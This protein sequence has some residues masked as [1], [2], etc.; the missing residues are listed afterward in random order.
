MEVT[1]K[2]N[3]GDILLHSIYFDEITYRNLKPLD[4]SE[5]DLISNGEAKLSIDRACVSLTANNYALQLTLT[6]YAEERFNFKVVCTGIFDIPVG[7][8]Q[9]S[10]HI[11]TVKDY[12][13]SCTAIMFPFLREKVMT[14]VNGAGLYNITIAPIDTISIFE[15][16][17]LE[18][19]ELSKNDYR[20]PENEVDKFLDLICDKFINPKENT[21]LRDDIVQIFHDVKPYIRKRNI[22]E[23]IVISDGGFELFAS[24]V[25][26]AYNRFKYGDDY[27]GETYNYSMINTIISLVKIPVHFMLFNDMEDGYKVAYAIMR[28]SMEE[29]DHIHG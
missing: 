25:S 20:I 11:P 8:V 2:K 3:P 23:N 22:D 10:G 26:D 7:F 18:I 6:G 29:G 1:I 5:S 24:K 13:T 16:K 21:K 14:L 17:D 28:N 12:L 27:R 15:G 9:E 4:I 19:V